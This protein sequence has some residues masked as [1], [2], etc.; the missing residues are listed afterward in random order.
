MIEEL[1]DSAKSVFKAI[2][3][4]KDWVSKD[5]IKKRVSSNFH[6]DI[7]S[8]NEDL[9]DEDE[10]DDYLDDEGE[11]SRKA[12]ATFVNLTFLKIVIL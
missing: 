1:S 4:T 8:N 5:N 10:E 7:D 12:H 3:S 11:E 9:R 6:N 2:Q